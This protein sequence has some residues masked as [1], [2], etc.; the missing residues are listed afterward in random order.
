[1]QERWNI[2][3]VPGDGQC[4]FYTWE[5]ALAASKTTNIK[6]TYTALLDMVKMEFLLNENVYRSSF[7]D[8]EID[9]KSELEKVIAQKSYGNQIA[10]MMVNALS[11]ATRVSAVIWKKESGNLIQSSF[12]QPM[13]GP[14]INGVIHIHKIGQH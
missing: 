8:Q 5:I 1:M 7:Y 4:L 14:S 11:S 2:I 13:H 10:D 3:E 12:V 9:L 6:P